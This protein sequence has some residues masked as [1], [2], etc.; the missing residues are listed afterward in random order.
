MQAGGGTALG[1]GLLTSVALVSQGA[2]GSMI[3]L[4]TDGAA[5]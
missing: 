2:P 1:P 5:S 4:V 3:I